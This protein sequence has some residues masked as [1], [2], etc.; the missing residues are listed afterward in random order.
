MTAA[1][2]LP[3]FAQAG[4][5]AIVALAA[6]LDLYCLGCAPLSQNEAISYAVAESSGGDFIQ[7]AIRDKPETTLYYLVLHGWVALGTSEVAL[8]MLS[9]I[10]ALATIPLLYALAARL[11]D[12]RTALVASLL[13][14]MNASFMMQSQN[15]RNYTL[16]AF[17]VMLASLILAI[18]ASNP[19]RAKSLLYVFAMAAAFYS[20]SLSILVLPVHLAWIFTSRTSSIARAQFVRALFLLAALLMPGVWLIV[21]GERDQFNWIP[22]LSALSFKDLMTGFIGAPYGPANSLR[23]ALIAFYAVAL[24]LGAGS[25]ARA[26]RLQNARDAWLM[27]AGGFLVPAILLIAISIVHSFYKFRYLTMSIPFFALFTAACLCM[28]EYRRVSAAIVSAIA[29]ASIFLQLAIHRMPIEYPWR[30]LLLTLLLNSQSDDALI[31][32]PPFLRFP[33]D[34]YAARVA[35]RGPL[36]SIAYPHWDSRLRLDGDYVESF[37]MRG[38]N[39]HLRLALEQRYQRLWLLMPRLGTPNSARELQSISAQYK[40]TATTDFAQLRL[41]R[42]D[43]C[44]PSGANH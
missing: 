28:T 30:P 22:P 21:R 36:P 8:R 34:Y 6:L 29:I 37:R 42:F 15:A 32:V 4:L 27:A 9:V 13:L 18:Y 12:T 3:T 41:I 40:C 23:R 17:L 35:E 2:R 26:F 19:S 24:A 33:F 43:N 14:A 16:P 7:L 1:F 11:F 5:I 38:D 10:F 31:I 44:A 39:P 20:H 25:V